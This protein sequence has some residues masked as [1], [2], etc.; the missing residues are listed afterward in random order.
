MAFDVTA[1]LAERVRRN[2]DTFAVY[3]PSDERTYDGGVEK[4]GETDVW[5]F[6]AASSS[7]LVTEGVGQDT[8]LTGLLEPSPTDGALTDLLTVGDEIRLLPEENRRYQVRTL[9][10]VPSTPNAEAV[11]VGLEPTNDST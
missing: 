1:V 2:A 7:Q 9:D 5:T 8:S 4:V 11:E 3:R 10:G 6:S